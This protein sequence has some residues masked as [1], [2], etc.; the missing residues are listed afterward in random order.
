MTQSPKKPAR[1]PEVVTRQRSRV[2][3]THLGRYRHHYLLGAILLLAWFLLPR[4]LRMPDLPGG[5]AIVLGQARP[6]TSAPGL[7]HQPRIVPGSDWVVHTVLRRDR[8]DWDLFRVSLADGTSQPVAVAPGVSEHGPAASPLGDEVAYVRITSDG[9]EVMV[10]SIALG[11]PRPI[12]PC[13][14]KFP[15]LVDWS[16]S[17]SMLAYTAP[18]A[19]DAEGLRRVYL[20][21]IVKGDGRRL[22]DAVSPTGTDFYPRFSPG[23]GKLAF[24]RGEPQPDHRTTLW[25]VDVDTGKEKQLTGLPAQLGGMAWLD[26]ERLI[27]SSLDAGSMRGR[28]V[29]VETGVEQAIESNGFMH[30][31]YREEDGTLVV[32][33]PRSDRDMAIIGADRDASLVAQSTSDDHSGRLSADE[34]WIAFIS[35]RSGFDELWI[36]ATDGEATRRLTSFDGATVRYPEWSPDG[37]KILITVQTDAGERLYIVDVVGGTAAPVDTTFDDITTPRW[38]EGGCVAGCRDAGGWGICT[39]DVNGVRRIAADYYRPHPAGAGNIYV[40]DDA[41]AL[42]NMAVTDGSVTKILDGMPAN[43]RYGWEVD[44]GTLYLLAGGETGNAGRLMRVDID[45]GEPET[46]YT[47]AMPVADTTISVGRQSGS[48]LLTLFQTSSDDLVVYENV[49][50]E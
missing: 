34:R 29:N 22:T 39:G 1:R 11:V 26:E 50:F 24:L 20:I 10:Q 23:G 46:L 25:V 36:A 15:T 18:Q 9:C 32:A 13:T 5:P 19:D 30:P 16:P 6:L 43:G 35:R 48:I 12:A 47:G 31:D 38:I 33:E 7:E 17:G 49:S 4:M 37:S 42:Y 21:D 3:A 40:V 8:G 27:Y 41:G 28:L 45:G 44:E 2:P 14:R